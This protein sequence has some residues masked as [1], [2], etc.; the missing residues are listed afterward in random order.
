MDGSP[1]PHP[2][3]TLD[4][5]ARI[6]TERGYPTTHRAAWHAEHRALQKLRSDAVIREFAATLFGVEAV[7]ERKA[8]QA[9]TKKRRG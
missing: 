6:L 4:E 1:N 9:A 3:M 7:A 8:P 5:V 2:V